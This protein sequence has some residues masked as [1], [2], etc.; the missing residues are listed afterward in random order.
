MCY[1]LIAA[2]CGKEVTNM[3]ML[4][5]LKKTAIFILVAATVLS[6]ISLSA[7]AAG[8]SLKKGS[9]GT[10]VA[11]LQLKLNVV[12][13]SD[14]EC[15]GIF[16]SATRSAVISFQR[17][18]S[19]T[20]DGI[21][22]SVTFSKLE[23]K[24]SAMEESGSSATVATDSLRVRD[25]GSLSGKVRH[26]LSPSSAITVLAEYN[27]WYAV[28][29]SKGYGFVS[30]Q[31]VSVHNTVAKASVKSVAMEYVG[32]PYSQSLSGT[33]SSS[34]KMYM[35][36][37]YLTK[38]VFARFSVTLP[39]TAAE[40]A[41]TCVN[42]GLEISKSALT[43]GDLIFYSSYKNG[44]YKNITHVAIYVGN[45]YIIDASASKKKVVYRKIW[46]KPILYCNTSS[47]L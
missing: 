32:N 46:G 41:R 9:K 4:T 12:R 14:L 25:R 18:Q 8:S 31:Y 13:N 29:Y 1:H 7:S 22:G 43:E 26:Y 39:R 36:C 19:I 23:K 42:K 15:D 6:V 38:T 17:S 3:R 11:E 2:S 37:S 24:L 44:R 34:G 47:L 33:L 10:E 45:G 40:Q 30:A 16:G 5:K 21:A 20:A 28:K 35:D 27:G